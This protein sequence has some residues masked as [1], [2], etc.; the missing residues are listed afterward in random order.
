MWSNFNRQH[1]ITRVGSF[2]FAVL[3]SFIP[4]SLSVASLIS[5]IPVSHRF[6][7]NSEKFIFGHFLP[8]TG[9]FFYQQFNISLQH[10]KNLSWLGFSVLFL[11]AYIA[12]RTLE[13]HINEMWHIKIHRT[14]GYSILIYA[15]FM[16]LGPI[17]VGILLLLQIAAKT[18]LKGGLAAVL[19]PI[20]YLIGVFIYVM[21]YKVLPATKV[22]LNHALAAGFMAGT[23]CEIAKFGFVFY[24]QTITLY[25]LIYGSLAVFPLFLIWVYI[26]S[27]ILFFCAHIVYVLEQNDLKANKTKR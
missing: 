25:D 13:K 11:T 15:F 19:H 7:H 8:S 3:L 17:L 24:A 21:I 18:Y 14:L 4:F 26:C 20:S 16:F 9:D 5:L 22:K 23:L 27:F 1:G 2:S 6:V 12:L 10:A